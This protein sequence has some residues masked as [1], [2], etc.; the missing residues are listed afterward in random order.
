MFS[1]ASVLLLLLSTAGVTA[2]SP[3]ASL[4][5]SRHHL[6][7]VASYDDSTLFG[8]GGYLFVERGLAVNPVQSDVFALTSNDPQKTPEKVLV[9]VSGA[10][11]PPAMAR[12]SC[13]NWDKMYIFVFSAVKN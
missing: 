10:Y 4:R 9:N 5:F 13:V 3:S 2:Q 8:F 6:S 1:A 7:L 11:V 12:Q